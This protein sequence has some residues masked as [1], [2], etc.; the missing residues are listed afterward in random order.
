MLRGKTHSLLIAPEVL[1]TPQCR[2]VLGTKRE[3]RS[4]QPREFGS[5]RMVLRT[6]RVPL[7]SDA[8]HADGDSQG[9][10]FNGGYNRTALHYP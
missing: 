2:T 7:A 8:G 5:S 4:V 3:V 1:C 6:W 10:G 9:V